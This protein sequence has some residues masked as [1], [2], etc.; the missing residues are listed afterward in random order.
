MGGNDAIGDAGTVALAAALRL[1]II[2]DNRNAI[3]NDDTV[4]DELD[5]SSCNVGDAGAEALALALSSN[6]GCL[7]RLNLADN[8]ISDA[9]SKSL[10]RA[11][12][13][14]RCGSGVVFEE[15]ILDNN[16]GIGDEGAVAL[17]EAMA[18]GAVRSI[19][20]RSCGV[21]AEGC[22]AFGK[23]LMELANSNRKQSFD[24]GD[25]DGGDGDDESSSSSTFRIDLSGNHFGT[26]KIKKKKGKASLIRDKASTNI[27]FIGKTLT[28]AAKRFG[29]ETMGI[30][31]DSDDDEEAIMGG[32]IEEDDEEGMDDTKLQSCGGLAFAGEILSNGDGSNS[33]SSRK[34]GSGRPLKISIGMRQ[35]RLDNGAIDALSACIVGAKTN[36]CDITVD[37]SMNSAED[38]AVNALMKRRNAT[39]KEDSR[40]LAS[41]ARR[42]MDFLDRIA[43]ARQRQSEA[44]DA[45]MGGGFFD[46]EEE[47]DL[48]GVGFDYDPY[49]DFD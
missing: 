35:C 29:S 49:D 34:I 18:V 24:D 14:A 4:L 27:K 47:D 5:L 12:V 43:D 15:I 32:L 2:T 40:L 38:N 20:V 8:E 17:A 7:L 23:A 36:N 45:A 6:P 42:H 48:Y 19:S 37:A 28:S 1:A 3:G 16:V 11:L 31:A 13:E 26:L 9:A 41:M 21:K 44:A 22:A 25:G 10:A 33:S 30:S 39:T 46:D